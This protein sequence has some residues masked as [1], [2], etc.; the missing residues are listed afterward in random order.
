MLQTVPLIEE[1]DICQVKGYD[2]YKE[3]QD[4]GRKDK[5][6]A[7]GEHRREGNKADIHR[8]IS[9]FFIIKVFK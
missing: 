9:R 2:W 3:L 8:A 6:V 4:K 5:Q 7:Q 1:Y